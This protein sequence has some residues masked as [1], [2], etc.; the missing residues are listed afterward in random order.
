MGNSRAQTAYIQSR[1]QE[2]AEAMEAMSKCP[3]A[4]QGAMMMRLCGNQKYQQ[5]ARVYFPSKVRETS[6]ESLEETKR[7]AANRVFET[8]A[9]GIGPDFQVQQTVL[10]LP[11][12]QGGMGFT[13][14]EEI[15]AGAFL[16]AHLATRS[17][18]NEAFPKEHRISKMMEQCARDIHELQEGQIEEDSQEA[19]DEAAVG[20]P[21]YA[22]EI[23]TGI[24]E[25]NMYFRQIN[26]RNPT[27]DV[28]GFEGNLE[29]L[30]KIAQKFQMRFSTL[31]G[32]VK[33]EQLKQLLVPEQHAMLRSQKKASSAP[34]LMGLPTGPNA[35]TNPE[36]WWLS[37][38]RLL[39]LNIGQ[40]TQGDQCAAAPNPCGYGR[41]GQSTVDD[42]HLE[43]CTA[44]PGGDVTRRHRKVQECLTECIASVGGIV[45]R[46]DANDD[47]LTQTALQREGFTMTSRGGRAKGGD[48]LVRNLDGRGP[49]SKPMVLDVTVISE[50]VTSNRRDEWPAKTAE[51]KKRA[52][53]SVMYDTISYDFDGFAIEIGGRLGP[54]AEALLC[55]LQK[56][57]WDKMGKAALPDE[58]N[59]TCPSFASYWRQRLVGAAQLRLDPRS[60]GRCPITPG[61]RAAG[62]GVGGSRRIVEKTE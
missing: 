45:A 8:T 30:T 15:A 49:T 5:A 9:V 58:A 37:Q 2:A 54:A 56:L 4:Q 3:S 34:F 7:I 43:I 57:W 17:Y 24:R 25:F 40:S 48:I 21:P 29:G 38:R 23:A 26:N 28:D 39:N 46:T 53:Y 12:R 36:M 44:V 55:R 20:I 42:A 47:I 31:L 6:Q 61:G 22:K 33:M 1:A 52:K 27:Q 41:A 50:R 62:G 35:I 59:W 18:A 14:V 32:D 60:D 19:A 51:E 10:K 11:V 16:A 13:D